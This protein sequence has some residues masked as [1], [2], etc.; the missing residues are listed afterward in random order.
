MSKHSVAQETFSSSSLYPN[1]SLRITL[2][3]LQE[4]RPPVCPPQATATWV[5]QLVCNKYDFIQPVSFSEIHL[6]EERDNISIFLP[7]FFNDKNTIPTTE[8]E[9][10]GE[11]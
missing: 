11:L 5:M 3:D 6:P 1:S 7:P 2:K 10:W 9:K 8:K 4:L